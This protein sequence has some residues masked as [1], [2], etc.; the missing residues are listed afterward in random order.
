MARSVQLLIWDDDKA[1]LVFELD[2]CRV[3]RVICS[4]TKQHSVHQFMSHLDGKNS[5]T[6]LHL[7]GTV[8]H[9]YILLQ[10]DSL[11]TRH[12]TRE[13]HLM[14]H[15]GGTVYCMYVALTGG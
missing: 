2:L 13:E 3:G 12:D 10:S 1:F 7:D 4:V 8:G 9:S 5:K 6:E 15:L 14:G 11:R